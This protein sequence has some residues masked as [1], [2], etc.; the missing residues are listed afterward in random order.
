MRKASGR[1]SAEHARQSPG[2]DSRSRRDRPGH[3][4]E[5]LLRLNEPVA[6]IDGWQARDSDRSLLDSIADDNNLDPSVLLHCSDL[7]NYIQTW[8]A[9]LT[10]KQ[11]A[12]VER[13]FGLCGFE[14]QTLE[15]VGQ[16]IGVT[17]E[18]VRQIQIEALERLRHMLKAAGLSMDTV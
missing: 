14:T 11:R 13:R 3:F 2:N 4:A 8:L 9:R 5:T 15:E 17:R 10:D 18:R 12:V 1:L 6:S 7:Q 16:E